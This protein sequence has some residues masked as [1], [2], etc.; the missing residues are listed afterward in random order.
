[1]YLWPRYTP[2]VVKESTSSFKEPK[3]TN[4][5]NADLHNQDQDE[6]V[7]CASA[8]DFYVNDDEAYAAAMAYFDDPVGIPDGYYQ[9]D[10]EAYAA[11]MSCL[12]GVLH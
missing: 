11:A 7:P 3:M 2:H 12:D 8:M 4:P 1:L 9:D 6:A 5:T 10:D